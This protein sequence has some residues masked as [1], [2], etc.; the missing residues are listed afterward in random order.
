MFYDLQ[1]SCLAKNCDKVSEMLLMTNVSSTI[2]QIVIKLSYCINF[3][4]FI[5][6]HK[7]LKKFCWALS[8]TQNNEKYAT[9][10][11]SNKTYFNIYIAYMA[12][13]LNAQ[14]N[15]PSQTHK[16]QYFYQ[17]PPVEQMIIPEP[18]HMVSLITFD[19]Q[20]YHHTA[21]IVERNLNA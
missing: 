21:N 5:I 8:A 2:K 16:R 4:F 20:P 12:G 7:H 6:L 14:Q 10:H 15:L 19:N 17:Y 1:D 9:H 11:K 18:Y 13:L 3:R